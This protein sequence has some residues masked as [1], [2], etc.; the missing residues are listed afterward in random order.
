LG[1]APRSAASSQETAR[2]VSVMN[3]MT[4]LAELHRLVAEL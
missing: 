1:K 2:A 3:F 4:S